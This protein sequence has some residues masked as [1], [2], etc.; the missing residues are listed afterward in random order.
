MV[1]RI[2]GH[3]ATVG[4]TLAGSVIAR[5]AERRLDL[6][7]SLT[8]RGHWVHADR[9][10]GSY[11][12]QPGVGRADLL[13]LSRIPGVRLD[14]HLMVDDLA[15]EIARLPGA[16]ARVT[17]QCDRLPPDLE[18]DELV[19][20][21]R[22]RAREVWLAVHGC[23]DLPGL[24][25]AGADGVL[26]MLTPPGQPGHLADL[27]QLALVRAAVGARLPAGVDGGVTGAGLDSIAACGARYVVVGR[28]IAGDD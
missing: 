14:V 13:E 24:K 10:E 15:A 7:R 1:N 25:A 20:R 2:S 9:I 17:L 22:D 23:L 3:A 8:A 6:A 26:V 21:G 12:G 4:V 27:R 16:I 5:P 19:G 11:R 28:A 18:L